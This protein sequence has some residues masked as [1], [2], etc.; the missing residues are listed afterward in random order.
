MLIKI[1]CAIKRKDRK[2]ILEKGFLF[3]IVLYLLIKI[4][5]LSFRYA[6]GGGTPGARLLLTEYPVFV[7]LFSLVLHAV[8]RKKIL[9]Y[10]LLILSVFF[11]FWNILIIS[12]FMLKVDIDYIKE[13]PP[14]HERIHTAMP[15]IFKLFQPRHFL[16][17][18]LILFPLFFACIWSLFKIL[19]IGVPRPSVC[20][21]N[22]SEAD[23]KVLTITKWLTIYFFISYFAV[24]AINLKNNRLNVIE[25][26][27]KG[28]FESAEIVGPN[29]FEVI[30]NSDSLDEMIEYF[31]IKGE[32]ERVKHIKN[33]KKKI[34]DRNIISQIPPGG[35]K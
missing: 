11:I 18:I 33:I 28:F 20:A 1:P 3:S 4:F 13:F 27:E 23:A 21:E 24:T 17:K 32:E 8:W 12:E 26:K 29:H 19:G 10:P 15:V 16:H 6:W 14:L 25:L 5:F 7:L 30:E 9:L 35:L 2:S 22:I 34:Y 31:K